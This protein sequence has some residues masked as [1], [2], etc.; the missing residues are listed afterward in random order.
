MVYF[1]E[2]GDY[3]AAFGAVCKQGTEGGGYVFGGKAILQELGDDTAAGDEVNHG[4]GEVAVGVEGGG[5]LW[6]VVDQAFCEAESQG[7]DPVDD[8]E[9]VADDGGLDCGGS[10]GYYAGA[11][12]MEGFT[13]VG[14]QMC[15]RACA[16]DAVARRHKLLDP[17]TFEGGGDRD[18]VFVTIAER[19]GRL[20][21]SRKV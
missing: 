12:V 5:D 20:E 6:R 10:A 11:G 7:G 14:N 3:L 13:G 8:Y 15:W 16:A 21:H 18:D 4:D 19:G 1:G 2:I 17:F 9:G